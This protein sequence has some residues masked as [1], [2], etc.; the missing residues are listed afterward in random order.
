M[1]LLLCVAFAGRAAGGEA[2][3]ALRHLEPTLLPTSAPSLTP[4]SCPTAGPTA[5]LA[6]TVVAPPLPTGNGTVAD[7]ASLQYL[8]E[9]GLGA[10][11]VFVAGN[12]AIS[13]KITGGAIYASDAY[14]SLVGINATR[15]TGEGG[16]LYAT[17]AS[18]IEL[19]SSLVAENVALTNGGGFLL[20]DASTL[21]AP[22][23]TRAQRRDEYAG[24]V[25]AEAGSMVGALG[26][27]HH[28]FDAAWVE[29]N[30]ATDGGGVAIEDGSAFFTAG[31]SV[32]RNEALAAAASASTPR[33]AAGII[34]LEHDTS[35]V[36]ERLTVRNASVVTG[37]IFA[38]DVTYLYLGDSHFAYNSAEEGSC[39]YAE[40]CEEKFVLA[41]TTVERN[42]GSAIFLDGS[43]A[44]LENVTIRD[45]VASP[46]GEDVGAAGL[47][48]VKSSIFMKGSTIERNEAE[49]GGAFAVTEQSSVFSYGGNAITGNAAV[50][51]HGGAFL[52]LSSSVVVL[53]EDDVV[54]YNTATL[55]GGV[56]YWDSTTVDRA[57]LV[58]FATIGAHNDAG[59]GPVNATGITAS[60]VVVG[61]APN[62]NATLVAV[63]D[64]ANL[65][66]EMTFDE[67]VADAFEDRFPVWLRGCEMGEELVSWYG[68]DDTCQ[69]CGVGFYWFDRGSDYGAWAQSGRCKSCENGMI[70]ETPGRS[71]VDA[72]GCPGHANATSATGTTGGS[73][74]AEGYGG[75]LCATCRDGYYGLRD[76][77]NRYRC[78]KCRSKNFWQ[79]AALYVA[80][81][82]CT[83]GG[84]IWLAFS[85]SGQTTFLLI[86]DT[87]GGAADDIVGAINDMEDNDSQDSRDDDS[88]PDV[89]TELEAAE[90]SRFASLVVK[91]KALISFY[92]IIASVPY[93][94]NFSVDVPGAYSVVVKVTTIFS[95]SFR[96]IVS[97]RC[98]SPS[99]SNG[100][101]YL[102]GLVFTTCV[103]MVMVVL[104]W[105][106]FRI[107]V[108][109][110]PQKCA[111]YRQ[112]H[113]E[114][115][116]L[117]IHL[118][119][120]VCSIAAVQ[121]LVCD[122]FD[123]G[124]GRDHAS[125]LR[126]DLSV[127]CNG[128]R[129][130]YFIQPW[131]SL[132]ILIYPV[133]VPLLYFTLL[134]RSRKLLN[135]TEHVDRD[136]LLAEPDDRK[137]SIGDR[138]DL[139]PD[140]ES[141]VDR[142]EEAAE[143]AMS[144]KKLKAHEK[145]S[146][147]YQSRLALH[148]TTRAM[149][150]HRED[151]FTDLANSDQSWYKINHNDIM[152]FK[153]L[154]IDYEPRCY[155]WECIEVV[156]RVFSTA[157]LAAVGQGSKLQIAIALAVSIVYTATYIR[158][159][160]FVF[161]D[162]DLIAEIS[163]WSITLTLFVCLML[164][165]EIALDRHF[166]VAAALLV[167]AALLPLL[168]A[169][170][171][172]R[173]LILKLARDGFLKKEKEEMAEE[174]RKLARYGR[175]LS[176]KVRRSLH[177]ENA[178][179]AWRW[180]AATRE[181]RA[182]RRGRGAPTDEGA[183]RQPTRGAARPAT[184]T[185]PRRRR[186]VADVVRL[187]VP[188]SGDAEE[189]K[190]ADRRNSSVDSDAFA[191]CVAHPADDAPADGAARPALSVEDVISPDRAV[192]LDVERQ[193][194]SSE[195][196]AAADTLA[197][198]LV[199]CV[200]A[201]AESP[202]SD[203]GAGCSRTSAYAPNSPLKARAPATGAGSA[204]V[205]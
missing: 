204:G 60:P 147:D 159:K 144:D 47:A 69:P 106:G 84:M 1:L 72:F 192:H 26:T 157:I 138:A 61:Y 24:A 193:D 86:A 52:V 100:L 23:S 197:S 158:F 149:A 195:D 51:G 45:N 102:W 103:P 94:F 10:S 191:D 186:L 143:E 125:F 78:Y 154:W 180:S 65:P 95:F 39:V 79:T 171:V 83:V 205:A 124:D 128:D 163:G 57:N 17:S 35:F 41:R 199:A 88:D 4:S 189:E 62:R 132:M 175:A 196:L 37:V 126:E 156:R 119:L 31:S 75:I 190:A 40:L 16:F 21:V 139:L 174:K 97:T 170:F 178:A 22:N 14:V 87:Q 81:G 116:L 107:K 113:L 71:I 151:A 73:L 104:L 168:A 203:R 179:A 169:L 160:P 152:S 63:L 112:L 176:Q 164:R 36:G 137:N 98:L 28:I 129:Y 6:P 59:Y 85:E 44:H 38:T 96:D 53:R 55:G 111:S 115:V 120:P 122:D 182:R 93:I 89:D 33:A 134:F 19:R 140:P 118:L 74:C 58:T 165:A 43:H 8:I 145:R 11:G 91:A 76:S 155:W 25:A 30:V 20:A 161:D 27:G 68:D 185:P 131:A 80:V 101:Y 54:D 202:G 136:T 2:P 130:L 46:H 172:I 173:K 32:S 49:Y 50:G 48:T 142:A 150:F 148:R 187:L 153:F 166:G 56:A 184:T 133:G 82:I 9:A 77:H 64:P 201:P 194:T 34:Y 121:A 117:L 181:R 110:D 141:F 7:W 66:E 5:S 177:M 200:G 108:R 3:R 67:G 70:C 188:S 13:D 92:Q 99:T 135:P 109:R 42:E 146:P 127:N 167:V 183:A 198:S 29:R 18:L 12:Y 90:N 162:D 123:N 15:N 105:C 114:M